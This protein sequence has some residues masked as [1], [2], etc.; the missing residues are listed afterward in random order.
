MTFT[1]PWAATLMREG[2]TLPDGRRCE[3]GSIEWPELPLPLVTTFQAGELGMEPIGRIDEVWRDGDLI[4]ARGVADR[5]MTGDGA[6]M[7]VSIERYTLSSE[8]F[9]LAAA[10]DLKI[11]ITKATLRAVCVIATPAYA[12]ARF[13]R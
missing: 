8:L 12:G 1:Y 10:D 3:P 6:G 5:D 9:D 13:E 7:E 2:E 4:R 11:A